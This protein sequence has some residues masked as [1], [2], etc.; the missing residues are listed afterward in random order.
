[1]TAS[2][3]PIFAWRRAPAGLRRRVRGFTAF[4]ALLATAIL[5]I[6]SLTISSTLL[7]GRQQT[8]NAQHTLCASMLARSLMEEILRLPYN[9]PNGYTTLGPDPG[10]TASNRATFDNQDDYSGYTDGPTGITDLAG[11]TLPAQ[12]QGY[13]RTVTMT[14]VSLSPSGWG[15]TA[16][17]LLVTVT[18]TY[19]GQALATEERLI[20]P[21]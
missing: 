5:A 7:A 10:E 2:P 3:L 16:N 8:A 11:N 4:E 9:D 20:V 13:V 18:V 21:D 12:F 14:T 17:G 6:I 19:N 15:R 1:M